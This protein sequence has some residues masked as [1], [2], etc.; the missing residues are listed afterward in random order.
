[1]APTMDKHQNGGGPAAQHG[2]EGGDDDHNDQHGDHGA[3]AADGV[4]GGTLTLHI[5]D[6]GDDTEDG[7]ITQGIGGVPQHV[8]DDGPGNLH[9]GRGAVG[10]S[11]HQNGG[12]RNAHQGN[13][14]PGQELSL[15]ELDLVHQ[16]AEQR[17]VDSVPH[18]H[19]Q[20]D[21]RNC[22]HGDAHV[23]EVGVHVHVNEH[24][25][26]VLAQEVQAVAGFFLPGDHAGFLLL[27]FCFAS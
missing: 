17:A 16:T 27:Y 2:A 4:H 22:R 24:V 11:E 3:D 15:L 18:L 10:D 1:M 9:P 26:D 7:H 6:G 12:N 23:G 19:D 8:G 5:G 21:D 13:A 20:G 25:E 14:Q